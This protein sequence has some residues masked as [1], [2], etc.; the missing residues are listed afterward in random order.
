[1]KIIE[2]PNVHILIAAFIMMYSGRR[3]VIGDTNQSSSWG[4]MIVN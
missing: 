3:P 4:G 1:M 2:G